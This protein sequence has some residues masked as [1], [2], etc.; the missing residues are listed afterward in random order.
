[1]YTLYYLMNRNRLIVE[2][3]IASILVVWAGLVLYE[4][5]YTLY[6]DLNILQ[7]LSSSEKFK[8]SY[9]KIL[10]NYHLS[11]LSPL[12]GL[13]GGVFL[14][15]GKKI[16]W[17]FSLITSIISACFFAID[18]FKI[19]N[20]K[21]IIFNS[22]NSTLYIIVLISMTMFFLAIF[23]ILVSKNFRIKYAPTKKLWFVISAIVL[24]LVAD[25][26]FI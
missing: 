5:I 17:T 8:I 1:M 3:V 20:Q 23:F 18:L 4:S 19:F 6:I 21:G 22:G 14:L 7:R 16:G 9:L 24:M 2:R 12:L 26:I 15:F 25:L 13:I 11:M 10:K